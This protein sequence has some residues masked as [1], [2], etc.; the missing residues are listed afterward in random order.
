ML[1]DEK[2][3]LLDLFADP[4][5]WCQGAEARNAI[6]DAVHFDD[7]AA[8]AWDLTG[9]VC[10]L[11]GWARAL[12]LFHQLDEHVRQA[13]RNSLPLHH[14]E[15]AA[16]AALQDRNDDSGTTFDTVIGWLQSMPVWSDHHKVH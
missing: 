16:M 1:V 6:G 5:R 15:I 3:K 13:K 2:E 11:F 7:P 12:E 4:Q 8:V 10:L 14:P 9:A